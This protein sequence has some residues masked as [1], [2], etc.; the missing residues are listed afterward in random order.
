MTD[1]SETPEPL[2]PTVRSL[3]FVGAGLASLPVCSL[4]SI[5]IAEATRGE[6]ITDVGVTL[7]T[8]AWRGVTVGALAYL[9]FLTVCVS[10]LARWFEPNPGSKV[11]LGVLAGVW[12]LVQL[13]VLAWVTNI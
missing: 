13:V 8:Q 5:R 2:S 9:F 6:A 1:P 3:L 7:F 12:T 11:A 4:V 10:V